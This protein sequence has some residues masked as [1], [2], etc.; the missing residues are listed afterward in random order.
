MRYTYRLFQQILQLIQ[1]HGLNTRQLHDL[2][3][4]TVVVTLALKT[5]NVQA[6]DNP[7]NTSLWTPQPS[8]S[9]TYKTS[10][11]IPSQE[12]LDRNLKYAE[13]HQPK[14]GDANFGH[15]PDTAIICCQDCRLNPT[16]QL[17]LADFDTAIIR[18]AAGA[19]TELTRSILIAQRWGTKH[20]V[21][22]KHSDCGY[23]QITGKHLII[24]DFKARAKDPNAIDAVVDKLLDLDPPKLSVDDLVLHDVNYLKESPLIFPET[25]ITG[26]V[27]D[28]HTGKI[29]QVV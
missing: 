24:E 13:G 26:W 23:F 6:K 19:V 17:G 5:G 3:G 2:A 12:L 7:V 1:R 9:T 10:P 27:F 29:R 18:N 22:I 20:F 8:M 28:D 15:M 11:P 14:V 21:V 4:W 16:K 25:K